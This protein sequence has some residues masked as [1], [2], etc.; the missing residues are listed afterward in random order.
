M[1]KILALILAL[2]LTATMLVG[3]GPKGGDENVNDNPADVQPSVDLSG[4][5]GGE[6]GIVKIL[7][8]YNE[9]YIVQQ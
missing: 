8:Y 5:A 2:A 4:A 7:F 6:I 1:K 3:C 9:D